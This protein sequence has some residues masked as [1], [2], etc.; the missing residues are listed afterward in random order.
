MIGTKTEDSSVIS[1]EG[2]RVSESVFSL[3]EM[4]EKKIGP[5]RWQ[6]RR[7]R[8]VFL[9]QAIPACA[10]MLLSI[11]MIITEANNEP[12]PAPMPL[13]VELGI[14]PHLFPVW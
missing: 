2:V 5:T 8:N 10:A 11:C 13:V 12:K 9:I 4:T 7:H 3:P 6:K 1:V 14:L